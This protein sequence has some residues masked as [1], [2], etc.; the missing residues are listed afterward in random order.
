MRNIYNFH[1]FFRYKH[2]LKK[3][4]DTDHCDNFYITKIQVHNHIDN[5]CTL[6]E[7][8]LQKSLRKCCFIM[9]MYISIKNLHIKLFSLLDHI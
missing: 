3:T 8:I 2:S 4:H 7:V 5:S 1:S 6:V 9:K